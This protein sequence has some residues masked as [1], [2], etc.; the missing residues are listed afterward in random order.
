M[1]DD[2]AKIIQGRLGSLEAAYG[3]LAA[4]T[5]LAIKTLV[6]TLESVELAGFRSSD[7]RL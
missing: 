2:D 5:A 6:L 7:C 1:T 4:G 3:Q